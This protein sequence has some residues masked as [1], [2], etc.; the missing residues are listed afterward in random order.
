MLKP[1]RRHFPDCDYVEL[2]REYVKCSCPIWVDGM[3]DGKRVRRS[4][5]TLN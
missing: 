4:L 5:D 1:W 3:L 2:G